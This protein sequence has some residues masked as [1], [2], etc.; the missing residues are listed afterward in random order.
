MVE[1][2]RKLTNADS[3]HSCSANFKHL[4]FMVIKK[5]S[6]L[7]V[8]ILLTQIWTILCIFIP[9]LSHK[10][11]V[12]TLLRNHIH[13]ISMF[14]TTCKNAVITLAHQIIQISLLASCVDQDFFLSCWFYSISHWVFHFP[15]M[16]FSVMKCVYYQLIRF[17]PKLIT[18]TT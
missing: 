17:S 4:C 16:L 11:S 5:N 8:V 14:I 3:I 15:S 2:N 18:S 6:L 7:S 1:M 9:L 10:V 13:Y 12:P